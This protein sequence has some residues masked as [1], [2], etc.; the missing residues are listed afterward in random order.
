[1]A[2]KTQT[3]AEQMYNYYNDVRNPITIQMS[4]H[5]LS[6]EQITQILAVIIELERLRG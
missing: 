1:M 3:V 4:L 2:N 6:R 5:K